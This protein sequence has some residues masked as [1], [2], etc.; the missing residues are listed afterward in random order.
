M[1]VYRVRADIGELLNNAT[2]LVLD[3]DAAVG[4]SS[5]TVQSIIGAA[6]NNLLFIREIGNERAEII[7][8]HA[9]TAP[10]GN[11]VTLATNLVEPH[12]AGTKIYIVRADTVR[13]YH[14]ATEIDANASDTGLTA[15]AAAQDIDPTMQVNIYD[16]TTKT[17]GFY[18][19]RFIDSVNSVNLLYSD[20][21]PWG[22]VGPKFERN[23]IGYIMES[24]RKDL[25]QDWNKKFTKQMAIEEGNKCLDY[26]ADR[27]Q[28]W[29]RYLKSDVVL[30]QTARGVNVYDMPDSIY[31]PTSNRSILNIKLGGV[32]RPLIWKDEKEF[33]RIMDTAKHTQVRTETTAD[34]TEVAVDN[35][36]DFSDTGTIDIF[37]ANTKDSIEYDG[38]TRSA[39][40]G[41]FTDIATGE[42]GSVD[43]THVV[44]TDIWQDYSEGEP[45]YF[46]IRNDKINIYPLAGAEF[47]NRNIFIDYWTE[48]V[49]LD[50]ESDTIDAARHL[51]LYHWL[52]WK[53]TARWRNNGKTKI[54][55]DDFKLFSNILNQAIRMNKSNQRFK[56]TP[57]VNA[58]V[59]RG[60]DERF[61]YK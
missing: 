44:G 46:T 27:L 48:A 5:I 60:R 15:L 18:Y 28:H 42:D 36:Y 54:T 50:S 3:A 19:F 6:I 38:I 35:T 30:G 40:A 20:P 22:Q 37:T 31:D 29:S 25:S 13:F 51:A 17:S 4:A 52:M 26:M 10:S 43:A 41:E 14:A 53:G 58:I 7:A 61:N 9:V 11:T 34:D 33:D 59:Y 56:W 1:P 39:T 49:V 55:D 23:E 16:D 32:V 47:I 12:P 2:T 57:R 24:V 21:I 8:T 45:R